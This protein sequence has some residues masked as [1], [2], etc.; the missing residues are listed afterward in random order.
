M[1]IE[2]SSVNMSSKTSL[3]ETH[4]KEESLKMWIGNQRPNFE[5][6]NIPMMEQP[7]AMPDT[8]EISDEG[9]AMLSKDITN[10]GRVSPTNDENYLEISDEDKAKIKLIEELI[11]IFTG[12]KIKIRIPE[13]LKLNDPACLPTPVPQPQRNGWGMEYDYHEVNYERE[14]MSF[15]SEGVIKTS[16]GR[17]INFTVQLNMSREF[18][19]E[20]HI[21]F[22][23]G[24]A[25]IDPLVINFDAPAAGLTNT[26]FNFD[27]DSDGKTDQI[28]FASGGSGF[29]ALDINN[30]GI[31]NNGHELFGPDSGNGFADLAKHDADGNNWID[32]NDAV[33]NRLRIWTRDSEGN[34]KLFALGEKGVGAIYL[35]NVSSPFS[36]KGSNN[37][38]QGTVASTGIFIRENGTAGTIQHIDL[39]V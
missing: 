14:K 32:E 24:D 19:S 39:A 33:F 34:D 8:L 37:Q 13:R 11:R 17:E 30:D 21:R 27:L 10:T 18:A 20:Q 7:L 38:L 26:K 23:A 4:T 3:L 25:A 22:R 31:I 28:S 9:R 12:K 1:K 16:D 36:I 29:L 2:G 15:S 35:G 5:G 6:R